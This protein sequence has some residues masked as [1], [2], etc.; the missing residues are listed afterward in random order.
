VTVQLRSTA[1]MLPWLL[2]A[3]TASATSVAA[4]SRGA[5]GFPL[6]DSPG[7]VTL[8]DAKL[9]ATNIGCAPAAWWAGFVRLA[10][11]KIPDRPTVL[12][13]QK[14]AASRSLWETEFIG[15]GSGQAALGS[16]AD[17]SA[18]A[19]VMAGSS[20]TAATFRCMGRLQS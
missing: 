7:H 6:C 10:E 11:L 18:C 4:C 16:T 5:A 13:P 20:A 2:A 9:S 3:I 19:A 17:A 1:P 12:D 8:V 14:L 15:P